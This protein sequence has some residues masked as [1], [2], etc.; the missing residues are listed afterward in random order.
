MQRLPHSAGG[1]ALSLFNRSGVS[2]QF[3]MFVIF[4]VCPIETHSFSHLGREEIVDARNSTGKNKYEG[5]S[6][7]KRKIFLGNLHLEENQARN[8]TGLMD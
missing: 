8:F 5:N 3:V 4:L 6:K 7:R 1:S 2:Q